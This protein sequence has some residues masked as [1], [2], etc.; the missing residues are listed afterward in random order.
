MKSNVSN[1]V[2]FPTVYH[3]IYCRK[4]MTLSNQASRC[5]CKCVR[6]QVVPMVLKEISFI[7][8]VLL[9]LMVICSLEQHHCANLK[10]RIRKHI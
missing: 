7:G 10:E 9:A 3:R 4:F 1:E 6:I 5:I 2:E 8:H